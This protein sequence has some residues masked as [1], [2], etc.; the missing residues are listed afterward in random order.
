VVPTIS[1]QDRAAGLPALFAPA[2]GPKKT[3]ISDVTKNLFEVLS[4]NGRLG[5]T[6]G[7]IEGF[8]ELFAKYKGELEVV[9]TSAG[10]LPRDVLTRLETTLKQSQAAQQAKTLRIK[11]KVNPSILGGLV[12]DFGDKTVDLSVS[13]RVTKLNSVLQQSI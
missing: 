11:N 9:V 6:E 1:A 12:I 7:V 8:A 2:E 5:E 3:P 13:A 4:E 10:P